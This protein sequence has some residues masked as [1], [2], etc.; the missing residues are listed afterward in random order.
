MENETIP[1]VQLAELRA[2]LT[3]RRSSILAAWQ[4]SVKD[5]PDLTTAHSLP[6]RQFF[7]H[8][9]DLLDVYTKKLLESSRP[10][11]AVSAEQQEN[12]AAHGLLRW[13]QGYDLREVI[14]EWGRLQNCLADELQSYTVQHHPRLDP[15]VV[16][17]AWRTLSDLCAEG[18]RESAAQYYAL[19]QAEAAGHVKD[20]E[21]ALEELRQLERE[22]SE[23]WRHATHDLR[24]NLGIVANATD[25]LARGDV[26]DAIKQ[27]FIDVLQKNVSSLRALLDDMTELSRLRAG[28]ERIRVASFDAGALLGEICDGFRGFAGERGLSLKSEGPRS[29]SVEGDANK[30]RRIAQNLLINALKYTERGGVTLSWG[31]SR[32]DDPERWMVCVLDTGPGLHS[33]PGAPLAAALEEATDEAR[34]V[35]RTGHDEMREGSVAKP[36]VPHTRIPDHRQVHQEHGEGIGLSIVKRLCELL[37][38]SLEIES[39]PGKGTVCRVLL[40]RVLDP[41]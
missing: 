1:D 5:D 11:T 6:R 21:G 18:V 20:L 17:V 10:P 12:A 40:P 39:A 7:D 25:G 9:P 8:I 3:R 34:Q 22:Q 14:K 29:F 33:G 32:A 13:Q 15:A 24:G 16:S 26:P 37:D 35:Q 30:V 38:A 4:K 28:Q 31:D 27:I 41:K 36:P 2:H 19:Q 23:L